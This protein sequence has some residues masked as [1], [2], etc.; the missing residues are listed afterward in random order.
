MFENKIISTALENREAYETLQ[1]IIQIS[2]FSEL[3]AIAWKQI[4]DYYSIDKFVECVDKS[5]ILERFN[6]RYPHREKLF[7]TYIEGLPKASSAQNIRRLLG[8]LRLDKLGLKV[9]DALAMGRESHAR[10]LMN[11]YLEFTV[12]EQEDEETVTEIDVSEL[13]TAFKPENLIPISPGKLCEEI[14]GG[15]PRGSQVGIFARTNVGKSTFAINMCCGCAEQGYRVLYFGNED[16]MAVS[17]LRA[18]CRLTGTNQQQVAQ[19]TIR[20][21]ESITNAIPEPGRLQFTAGH[22]GDYH[23]LRRAIEVAKPDL[24]VVDQIRNMRFSGEG[25][26]I[27]LDRGVQA[28][29][30]LAKE[31]NLVMVVVTQ[32][33]ESARNKLVLQLEDVEWSNTAFQAQMDLLIAL[34]SNEQ[35]REDSRLMLS[36][37]KW[38][39]GPPILPFNVD[40]DFAT[41]KITTQD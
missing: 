25:M 21:Q 24:V 12:E 40:V 16:A 30:S 18:A 36:F 31:F 19:N 2:E 8:Q 17:K 33:G 37:P 14:G 13:V 10:E 29:R 4:A 20:A 35:F 41:Q 38:K 3:G 23:S 27:N 39:F 22:P 26:T 11:E 34:G 28:T 1:P 9:T 5:I 6:K 32:A 7:S 15:L